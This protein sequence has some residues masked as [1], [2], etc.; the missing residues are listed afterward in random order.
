MQ[1]I[2]WWYSFFMKTGD[3]GG[4]NEEWLIW[5]YILRNGVTSSL[6]IR[7]IFRPAGHVVSMGEKEV[8]TE[9]Y[10]ENIQR[11]EYMRDPWVDGKMILKWILSKCD[12]NV[13][14]RW[15]WLRYDS[16]CAVLHTA[17][18][19]VFHLGIIICHRSFLKNIFV[20]CCSFSFRSVIPLLTSAQNTVLICNIVS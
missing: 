11:M 20:T 4:W 1:E 19:I 5:V 3:C 18:N 9:F 10:S 13:S 6:G 16:L 7:T 17:Q 12:G 2:Y 14:T 8:W 15:N